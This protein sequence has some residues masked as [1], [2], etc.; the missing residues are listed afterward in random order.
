MK[1]QTNNMR[2]DLVFIKTEIVEKFRK[3]KAVGKDGLYSLLGVHARTGKNILEGKPVNLSTA[4]KVANAIGLKVQS[5]IKDWADEES[6][7][8]RDAGNDKHRQ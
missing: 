2:A 7:N 6:D 3:K 1:S 8:N 5:I 4:K